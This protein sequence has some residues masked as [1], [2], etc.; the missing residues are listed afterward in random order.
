MS[1]APWEAL[2]PSDP[3]PARTF[4]EALLYL[5][6]RGAAPLGA[7]R[8]EDRG[9]VLLEIRALHD[10]VEKRFAFRLP[11]LED[12]DEVYLGG[13]TPSTLLDPADLVLFAARVSRE[14]P[15]D[16]RSIDPADLPRWEKDLQL[17]AEAALEATKFVPRGADTPPESCF[18]TS[19]ARWLF[20]KD[21]SRF[22]RA[23]L[24]ELESALR[25]RAA[26][27]QA[28]LEG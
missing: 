5:R 14:A 12:A 11:H 7:R 28:A 23:S 24:A 27:F 21:P 19:A 25:S 13:G 1:D 15:A 20:R 26:D 10:G 4:N 3:L 18:Q 22:S 16:P 2:P 8:R 6:V 17:A 9:R